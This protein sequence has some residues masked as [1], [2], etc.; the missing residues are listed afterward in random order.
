MKA[1]LIGVTAAAILTPVQ[2]AAA[3]DFVVTSV[4]IDVVRRQQS[5]VNTILG[6]TRNNSCK[7]MLDAAFAY[8]GID[9]TKATTAASKIDAKEKGEDTR[10]DVVLPSGYKYCRS[11]IEF[12]SVIPGDDGRSPK[13]AATAKPT[14]V[15]VY[16]WTPVNHHGDGKSQIKARMSVLGVRQDAPQKL[17]EANSCTDRKDDYTI[18]S[19][20]GKH[21][22]VG[23]D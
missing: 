22:K 3:E 4:S 11:R 10:I 2:V 7:A 19:C 1:I 17:L 12:D 8:F 5:F 21:C 23:Q 6:C 14:G 13:F 9:S 20:Q 15:H 18:Y 16:T